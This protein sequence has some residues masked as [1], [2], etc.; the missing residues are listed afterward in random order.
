MPLLAS[1]FMTA[2]AVVVYLALGMR[3]A[4]WFMRS[5]S[6]TLDDWVDYMMFGLVTATGPVLSPFLLVLYGLGR[7]GARLT[8]MKRKDKDD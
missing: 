4:R 7:L 8:G 5:A 6:I 2:A 1:I 3:L